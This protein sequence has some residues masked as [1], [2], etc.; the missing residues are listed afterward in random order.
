MSDLLRIGR[1]PYYSFVVC[2]VL[3]PLPAR[4]QADSSEPQ[5]QCYPAPTPAVGTGGVCYV[6]NL[7]LRRT[8]ANI[9]EGVCSGDD[10]KACLPALIQKLG[11]MKPDDRCEALAP[12]A[13]ILRQ[14]ITEMVLTASLQVDGFLAEID[15]ETS[16]IRAVHDRLSDRRDSAISHSSLG[17][18]IGTGGGAVGSALALGA[19]TVV[20]VGS[21]VGAV[22]GAVGAVYGFRGY[23]QGHGPKGCFPNVA[24]KCPDLREPID[25]VNIPKDTCSGKGCSPSMLSYL[26]T[27]KDPGFH[28]EYE[29]VIKEYLRTR[30][31][32]LI[33]QWELG[34]KK[35]DALIARNT[36]PRKL[37][38]D[39]LNDRANKLA[40][41]RAVVSR[42]KRDLSRLMQDLSVG[43]RCNP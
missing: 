38:I 24:E 15:S 13:L 16:Q 7:M 23:F 14:E 40:D 10:L 35:I 36:E 33:E 26:L 39:E 28:S 31:Q 27:D 5:N 21:W 37:S 17:S 18:A 9:A 42:A 25:L 2:L 29:P 1:L 8:S 30:K 32:E 12:R 34:G 11:A 41:V 43:L 4:G 22:S 19:N 20:T 3:S 6:G